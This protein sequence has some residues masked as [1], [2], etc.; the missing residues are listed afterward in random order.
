[1]GRI[2]LQNNYGFVY[3]NYYSVLLLTSTLSCPMSLCIQDLTRSSSH[4]SDRR[5]SSGSRRWGTLSG[6]V[7]SKSGFTCYLDGPVD[8][9]LLRDTPSP[10]PLSPLQDVSDLVR[11]TESDAPTDNYFTLSKTRTL[12]MQEFWKVVKKY[13]YFTMYIKII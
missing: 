7:K 9:P 10:P 3:Y 12:E 4:S 11:I 2:C 1:M 13:V 6:S 8:G 5:G